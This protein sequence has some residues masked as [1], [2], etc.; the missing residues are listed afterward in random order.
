[1]N[2]TVKYIT[3]ENSKRSPY[4]MALPS[5]HRSLRAA[6]ET[7]SCANRANDMRAEIYDAQGSLVLR[8]SATGDW[9]AP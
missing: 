6:L 3:S 1:M 4:E 5:G 8:V 9:S 7:A 2:Y